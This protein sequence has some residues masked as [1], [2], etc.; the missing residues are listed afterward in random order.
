[1]FERSLGTCQSSLHLLQRGIG[2]EG[3]DRGNVGLRAFFYVT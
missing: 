3:D 2:G 1:M